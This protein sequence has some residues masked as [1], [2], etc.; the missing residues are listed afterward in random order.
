MSIILKKRI[1]IHVCLSAVF[2]GLQAVD[3]QRD[4]MIS[5]NYADG[6]SF[7]QSMGM[8][9]SIKIERMQ[10]DQIQQE[11]I[12]DQ[13]INPPFKT[14]NDE[15]LAFSDSAFPSPEE[16]AKEKEQAEKDQKKILELCSILED[17]TNSFLELSFLFDM[18]SLNPK[19]VAGR[20]N[21][22]FKSLSDSVDKFY[23][24]VQ[25]KVSPENVDEIK[26]I[27][28][29]IKTE[30]ETLASEFSRKSSSVMTNSDWSKVQAS[31]QSLAGKDWISL[32]AITEKRTSA[33]ALSLSQ[34]QNYESSA[35]PIIKSFSAGLSRIAD[36]FAG[37]KSLNVSGLEVSREFRALHKILSPVYILRGFLSMIS[38]FANN[39]P[40]SSTQPATQTLDSSTN[41]GVSLPSTN[42]ST[43]AIPSS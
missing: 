25:E 18:L 6:S 28:S 4:F 17:F 21:L 26:G 2:S 38:S 33:T 30:F 15:A 5:V 36:L 40:Q 8:P 35:D 27:V 41:P 7:S 22:V 34:T 32:F 29:A 1:F 16:L 12:S 24:L 14:T 19:A 23:N 39:F 43:P 42:L 13:S 20:I 11:S 37:T 9:L 31:L 10:P 3:S